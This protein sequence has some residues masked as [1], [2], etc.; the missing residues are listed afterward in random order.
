MVAQA[1]TQLAAVGSLAVAVCAMAAFGADSRP[2]LR[3]LAVLLPLQLVGG[4]LVG[5]KSQILAPVILTGLV[6]VVCR[7]RVPWRGGAAVLAATVLVLIPANIAYRNFLRPPPNQAA[8]SVPV[9]IVADTWEYLTVRFRLIDH[10]AL[11]DDRTP[12]LF[13]Y[14]N[15]SRYVTLP[16][17]V[18][19]PRAVW[20]DKPI[21]DD[22]LEFS[23]TYWEIPPAIRT[24]TPLTQV[25][26]LLRNFGV[27]GAL[28]G[29]LLWGVVVG[30]LAR[31][32][33][34][35]RSPRVELLFLLSS[36]HGWSTWR[37]ISHS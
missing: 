26:D 5:Y 13:P 22:G 17:L 15:R 16:A 29:M 6:Y 4:F 18:A 7:R 23:H 32:R 8:R 19:L 28:V 9:A 25:G 3:L 20:P 24:S 12:E 37:R 34:R 2:H 21:L 10:V 27:T 14:A 31:W 30:G 35:R 33:A 1:L 11:I 36:P